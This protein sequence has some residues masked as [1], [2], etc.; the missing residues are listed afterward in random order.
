[1]RFTL[2]VL[3]A[4]GSAPFVKPLKA[5]YNKPNTRKQIVTSQPR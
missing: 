1:M 3:F 5:A 4:I 2:H